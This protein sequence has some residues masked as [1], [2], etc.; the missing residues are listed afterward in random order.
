MSNENQSLSSLLPWELSV[1]EHGWSDLL[2]QTAGV[3]PAGGDM[4]SQNADFEVEEIPAYMPSGH[5]EHL[6]LWI[7]KSGKSTQDALKLIQKI[8]EVQEIDIGYAGKKD[9]HAVTRQWISVQTPKDHE[10]AIAALSDVGWLK[11]LNVSRHT[12]KLRMGHLKG[13]RFS[14]NVY[15]V[16][17]D[18]ASIASACD[19]VK[20][21]G[22]I[23]YF[24]KQRFGFDGGNVREGIGV[25]RGARVRRQMKMMYISAVQSALFN[26][27]AAR[28]YEAIQLKVCAGDIMQKLHA[29]CFVCDDPTTDTQRV[30]QGE[31]AATLSLSGKKIMQATGY[32]QTLEQKSASDFFAF[33]NAQMPSDA[34]PLTLEDLN[35]FAVG[36][37]RQFVIRPDFLNFERKTQNM[38]NF[39]FALPSG[40]YAT[41]LLR[42]LCGASFT[43]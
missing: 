17:A 14:V 6:Y 11:V 9:A 35:K 18:D 31:I 38:I 4:G 29:G 30:L 37:R 20:E 2:I 42:L 15:G 33:W 7:E 40:A 27:S 39:N 23:N 32:A 22:F 34:G 24:G 5:G 13:N 10:A 43:R 26:L 8:F 41:V 36:D 1:I 12:N 19:M 3:L 21:R 25:M 16:I 28:R